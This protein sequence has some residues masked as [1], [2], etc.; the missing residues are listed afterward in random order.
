MRALQVIGLVYRKEA[1]ETF[2]DLRTLVVMVVLPLALYPLMALAVAQWFGVQRERVVPDSAISVG[3]QGPEWAELRGALGARRLLRVG[4]HLSGVRALRA[5]RIDA[6]LRLPDDLGPRLARGAAV[7]IELYRDET[8]ASSAR[9]GARLRQRLQR[10]G[11]QQLAQR[12]AARGL[13]ADFGE[14][15][16]L[17]DHDVATAG[18]AG[19]QAVSGLLPLLI[20]LM[21][22]LGAF[23]P[24]IDLTAGEK[25]RG[26]LETLLSTPAPRWGL[27][28]GKFLVVATVAIVTGVVNLLSMGLTLLLGFGPALR[29][30]GLS[31]AVPWTAVLGALAGLVPAS[32]FFAA[33]LL[34]AATLA[35][36][37][38]EAQTLLAPVYVLCVLPTMAAQLPGLQLGYGAA[39]LP[40]VNVSMLMQGL[41]G[42]RIA[43]G[44]LWLALLS[45]IAHAALALGLA[46]RNFNTERLLFPDEPRAFASGTGARQWRRTQ[47]T[48]SEAA[49]LLLVVLALMLLV[50]QPLQQARFI[51]GVLLTEWLMVALPVMAFLRWAGLAPRAVLGWRRPSAAG[52]IG[53]V[54]AGSSGWYLVAA[55]VEQ[56]QQRVLPI[57]PEVVEQLRRTVFAAERPLALDLLVLAISP[58]ICEEL[59]FRGVLLRASL[60][61]QRP[62]LAVVVNGLLFGAFH[63]S[64]YRFLPTLLLGLVL[65]LL[66]VRSGSIVL[67]MVFHLAN[68]TATV[69]VARL[70]PPTDAASSVAFGLNAAYLALATVVFAAG[71]WLALRRPRPAPG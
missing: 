47:P 4:D 57:P 13:A 64:V 53:A 16:R 42:G 66:V 40:G 24:A 54:L 19:A 1:L 32:L 62:W 44:P 59:L 68:N 25:E 33:V 55:V 58:A 15:L 29:A 30:A 6:F 70:V 26:T 61:E 31:T 7:P 63:L 69:L 52:L 60:A 5:G 11:R 9:A 12:L 28:G 36:S 48:P 71:C 10:F 22:L 49:V 65:A 43:A 37:F 18:A 8:S 2:R 23:Y 27:I 46:A 56:L 21:V 39:L 17:Q 20:V 35:R 51:P 3:W 34:A 38:K 50:G 67:A 45:S 14:P 41:A